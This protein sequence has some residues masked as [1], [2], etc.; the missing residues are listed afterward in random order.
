MVVLPLMT[1][2]YLVH[3]KSLHRFVGYLEETAC[4]T[5]HDLVTLTQ[6]E[7]TQLH[8]AWA[9]LPAP[10]I[11]KS[12]WQ[13]DKKAMWVDVLKNLYAD[14][15]NHR[16][17]NHTF[18]KMQG[19]DPNPHVHKHNEDAAKAWAKEYPAQVGDTKWERTRSATYVESQ[20]Q[21]PHS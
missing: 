2:A 6:M 4:Q 1:L 14:E 17:V 15:S 5:Y 10:A 16:D 20:P 9:H 12:Y 19:D 18:A 8:A 11:A 21:M 7:G 13:M 3:P